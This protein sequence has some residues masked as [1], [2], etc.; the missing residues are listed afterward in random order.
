M[1]PSDPNRLLPL[2]PPVFSILLTLG[3]E[4]MH[5][6][7][8]MQELERRTDGRETLLPGSLYATIARMVD[9]QLIEEVRAPTTETD[10][11]RRFYKATRFGRSVARAEAIRLAGLVRLAREQ[12]LI[13]EEA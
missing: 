1:T 10:A 9:E 7:A 5:G 2:S 6:Y 3:A 13:G 11:R 12:K 4:A 8:I